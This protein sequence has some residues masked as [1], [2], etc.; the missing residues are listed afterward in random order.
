MFN[1]GNNQK[2]L[3]Q[4]LTM[5]SIASLANVELKLSCV[6]GTQNDFIYNKLLSPLANTMLKAYSKKINTNHKIKID[7]KKKIYL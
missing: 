4:F 2:N 5:E 3:L 7:R 6:C 1:A